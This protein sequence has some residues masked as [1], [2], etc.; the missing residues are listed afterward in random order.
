MSLAAE[1]RELAPWRARSPR[2]APA[3]IRRVWFS[4]KS[5]SV[6]MYLSYTRVALPWCFSPVCR[7]VEKVFLRN[8]PFTLCAVLHMYVPIAPAQTSVAGQNRRLWAACPRYQPQTTVPY[9][10]IT[11]V[12]ARSRERSFATRPTLHTSAAFPSTM[13][14]GVALNPPPAP[15]TEKVTSSLPRVF[16]RFRRVFLPLLQAFALSC[17]LDCYQIVFLPPARDVCFDGRTCCCCFERPWLL[18]VSP[19]RTFLG[20]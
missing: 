10:N 1:R 18:L 7:N 8:H 15:D 11:R 14:F 16:L 6:D 20:V 19:F 13:L 17:V 3:V 4:E 2:P 9:Y 5:V 12:T